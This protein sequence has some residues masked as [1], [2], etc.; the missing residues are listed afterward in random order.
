MTAIVGNGSGTEGRPEYISALLFK[1]CRFSNL[2]PLSA[3]RERV[4]LV[5]DLHDSFTEDSILLS[6]LDACV[7]VGSL[8]VLPIWERSVLI[9]KGFLCGSCVSSVVF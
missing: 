4:R 8:Q 5:L 6:P 1:L 3:D 7:I 9:L 2:C